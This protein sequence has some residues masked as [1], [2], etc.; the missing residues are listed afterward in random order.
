MDDDI[1]LYVAKG[2][3]L[4]ANPRFEE[5]TQ[6]GL[7]VFVDPEVV[8]S[9]TQLA[10]YAERAGWSDIKLFQK[11]RISQE[12]VEEK[13]DPHL[14]AWLDARQDGIAIIVYRNE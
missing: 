12:L 11:G 8:T 9:D 1:L 10:V 13:G 3:A 7:L 2:I 6:H 5:G 14:S 4:G